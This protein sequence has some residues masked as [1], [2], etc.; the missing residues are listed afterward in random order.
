MEEAGGLK[1]LM[2]LALL[3]NGPVQGRTRMMKLLFLAQDRARKRGIELDGGFEFIPYRFGPWSYEV[4]MVLEELQQEGLVVEEVEE[5]SYGP[6]F[7]YFLTRRGREEAEKARQKLPP[8]IVEELDRV[9]REWAQRR[10][11]ELIA[12]IYKKYPDYAPA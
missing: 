5:T 6:R 10:L 12:Y 4:L 8:E 3:G 1:K 9:Y 2:V 11:I 7:R